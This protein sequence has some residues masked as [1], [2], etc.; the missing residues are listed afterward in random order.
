MTQVYRADLHRYC[1]WKHL[2]RWAA[3]AATTN[4]VSV[5]RGFADPCAALL[6]SADAGRWP[7]EWRRSFGTSLGTGRGHASWNPADSGGECR[8]GCEQCRT[9]PRTPRWRAWRTR[10][11]CVGAGCRSGAAPRGAAGHR[12]SANRRGAAVRDAAGEFRGLWR[13]WDQTG[14]GREEVFFHSK[15]HGFERGGG[16]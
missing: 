16:E 15:G 1:H 11:E 6:P 7:V 4:V 9:P 12:P 8:G 10:P 3:A 5:G 2:L 14:Q 13:A